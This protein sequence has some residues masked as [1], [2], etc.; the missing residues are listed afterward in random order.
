MQ[1]KSEYEV[2]CFHMNMLIDIVHVPAEVFGICRGTKLRSK[3]RTANSITYSHS[4]SRAVH[5]HCLRTRYDTP[6]YNDDI[7]RNA[8][9]TRTFDRT[10]IPSQRAELHLSHA[11]RTEHFVHNYLQ[12]YEQLQ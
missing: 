8:T 9:R 7:Y 1:M 12:R 11:R 10:L 5:C 3:P 6:K 4:L 2:M